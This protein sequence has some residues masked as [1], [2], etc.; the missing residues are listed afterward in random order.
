MTKYAKPHDDVVRVRVPVATH[1][2]LRA[3]GTPVSTQIRAAIELYLAHP[4]MKS[5]P[6]PS[7]KM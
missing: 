4:A 3:T 5:N 6:Q 2:A 1:N 7:E